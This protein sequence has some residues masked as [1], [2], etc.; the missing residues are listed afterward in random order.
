MNLE[1]LTYIVGLIGVVSTVCAII[2]GYGA[3]RRN[4]KNDDQEGAE[5]NGIVLTEI[6]YIKSGVDDI[7]RKQE[8][9]DAQYV[10]TMSRLTAVETSTN[11]A[12]KRLDRF[13][14]KQ[15]VR[16]Q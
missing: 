9:Q 1:A 10:E 8:K 14:G 2:F 4:Q 5:K 7:K 13:E 16:A 3:F 6:G 11:Q 15:E 12:H